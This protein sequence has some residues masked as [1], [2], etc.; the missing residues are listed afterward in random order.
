MA[1]QTPYVNVLTKW[2]IVHYYLFKNIT[3]TIKPSILELQ[4][5]VNREFA[6]PLHHYDI[7][8]SN[9]RWL[10]HSENFVSRAP[11]NV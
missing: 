6:R 5:N 4:N 9:V 7:K 8:I 11:E 3:A 1:E 2:Q 10:S